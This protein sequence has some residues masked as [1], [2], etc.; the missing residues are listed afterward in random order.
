MFEPKSALMVVSPW[1]WMLAMMADESERTG[2]ELTS[3]FHALSAGNIRQ[4]PTVDPLGAG[5][6]A[7]AGVD[8]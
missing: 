4:P 8:S 7:G 5:A 6:G 1:A 3:W 2:S